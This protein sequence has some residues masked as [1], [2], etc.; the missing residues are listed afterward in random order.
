MAR[1][2]QLLLLRYDACRVSYHIFRTHY[3]FVRYVFM[4][5]ILTINVCFTLHDLITVPICTLLFVFDRTCQIGSRFGESRSEV[6]WM[7]VFPRKTHVLNFISF[8]S[9][10]PDNSSN[11]SGLLLQNFLYPNRSNIKTDNYLANEEHIEVSHSVYISTVTSNTVLLFCLT[12]FKS[13]CSILK[14]VPIN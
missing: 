9:L 10:A 6:L 12:N 2:Y 4:F 13:H 7:Q 1:I 3:C 14:Y 8:I 11:I 5:Y